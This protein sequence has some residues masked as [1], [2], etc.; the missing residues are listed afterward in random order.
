MLIVLTELIALIMVNE[1]GSKR[2]EVEELIFLPSIGGVGGG[3]DLSRLT[4][5]YD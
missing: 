3:S 1:A 4:I 5:A 2:Q